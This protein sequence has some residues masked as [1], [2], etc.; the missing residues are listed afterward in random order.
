MGSGKDE[1][2]ESGRAAETEEISVSPALPLSIPCF[3]MS[4]KPSKSKPQMKWVK[5]GIISLC[6][7]A[8]AVIFAGQNY[9]NQAWWTDTIYWKGP[10]VGE[11]V[12]A[13]SWNILT[14]LILQL[15]NR[16]PLH[17]G[18]LS[19]SIVVHA[20]A[21]PFFFIASSAITV[22]AY[23]LILGPYP[24]SKSLFDSFRT[25]VIKGFAT[26]LL[27][28]WLIIGIS[29]AI[30]YYRRYRDRELL[31]SNLETRLVEAQLDALRMQLHPHFLFNTL[32]S[33]S[34][35]MR[36]DVDA[37]DRMLL[38]LSNLLRVTLARNVAH[39]IK[40]RQEL[41]ILERYLEIEQIRFQDRLTVRMQVDPAALDALTPQLFFQPL[42]ENAIRHGVAERETGGV[43]EIRAERRDG[44]MRLEVRDNGPGLSV[45]RENLIE[46]VGLSNTRSRLGYLYGSESR[47]DVRNADEGGL[48][49]AAEF[50]FHTETEIEVEAK[51]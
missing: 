46:G 44:M 31:A 23:R 18:K 10:L 5:W 25:V 13:H 40:L 30:N 4:S 21:V 33:V 26:G 20:F 29:Q 22:I 16:F 43:I 41:E 11:L 39:E 34:V 48:I 12:W 6:W 42:V 9:A 38:Q 28:Y 8:L 3:D 1:E 19:R 51:G 50:P 47:F 32:N 45:S 27:I 7:T 17:R 35:L 2:R 49:V 37:A 24:G 15:L 36:R 14:P